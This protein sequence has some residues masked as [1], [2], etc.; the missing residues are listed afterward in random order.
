M[1]QDPVYQRL[2]EIGWRRPLTAAEQV[3]LR[4]WL[5]AHP[6]A[7]AEVESDEMLNAALVKLPDAPMPSNFTARVLQ[8]IERETAAER[9]GV[10][11]RQ[12]SKLWRVFLPRFAVATVLVVGGAIVYR[13][14]IA[15]QNQALV[16]A[17]QEVAAVESFSDPTVLAD[18][19][20]IASLSPA[21]TAVDEN[22][23]ALSEDLLAIGK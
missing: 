2:R 23:L 14:N 8:H 9:R 16:K 22:L 17:A 19:D 1:N 4:K 12:S 21:A 3:E 18:F 20:V 11:S 15:K 6:E 7:Q 5:A 13:G 10:P